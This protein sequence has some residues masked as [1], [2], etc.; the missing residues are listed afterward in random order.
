MNEVIVM[1]GMLLLTLGSVFLFLYL[2]SAAGFIGGILGFIGAV[3]MLLITGS[4]LVP[5]YQI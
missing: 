2:A 4:M 3:G 1:F 5:G